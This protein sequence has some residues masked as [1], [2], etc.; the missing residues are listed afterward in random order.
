MTFS[1]IIS[2]VSILK[3]TLNSR[4]GKKDNLY[5]WFNIILSIYPVS[6]VLFSHFVI[7]RTHSF[8]ILQNFIMSSM[9]L[10]STK[11][12]RTPFIAF[13]LD[14]LTTYMLECF[15]ACGFYLEMCLNFASHF[16]SYFSLKRSLEN[17]TF[18]SKFSIP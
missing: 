6:V 17:S 5:Y 16:T 12:G 3:N 9:V 7:G 10:N 11:M 8:L 13:P 18:K 14:S 15:K 1:I 2:E 4:K